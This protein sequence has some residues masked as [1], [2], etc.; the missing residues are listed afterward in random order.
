MQA[1]NRKGAAK[2]I[3]TEV[4]VASA[5]LSPC[6]GLLYSQTKNK[7]KA[8][9]IQK[10]RHLVISIEIIQNHLKKKNLNILKNFKFSLKF[11]KKDLR[12]LKYLYKKKRKKKH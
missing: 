7:Q 2:E 4:H 8:T 9:K 5:S 3:R 10:F 6:S 1:K 11:K 12:D